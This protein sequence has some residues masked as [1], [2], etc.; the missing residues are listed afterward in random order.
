M[1]SNES[2][3]FNSAIQTSPSANMTFI[4]FSM[5]RVLT[6]SNGVDMRDC[7][8]FTFDFSSEFKLRMSSFLSYPMTYS[9]MTPQVDSTCLSTCGKA[10]KFKHKILKM[11]FG[12]T[13][14]FKISFF[15]C[16]LFL[17]QKFCTVFSHVS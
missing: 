9:S 11:D 7:F 15:V 2:A 5:P 8:S 14:I 12:K 4:Y 6:F 13:F 10:R 17:S 16:L 3:F 1:T